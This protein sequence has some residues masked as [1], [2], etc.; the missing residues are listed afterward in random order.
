[1]ASVKM[2]SEKCARCTRFLAEGNT[3]PDRLCGY[4]QRAVNVKDWNKAGKPRVAFPEGAGR[5]VKSRRHAKSDPDVTSLSTDYL[6]K[7][8]R[9]LRRRAKS[10]AREA[11]LLKPFMEG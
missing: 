11:D 10:L 9:E 3:C 1:M 4:C 7:C 2:T 8:E 6:L 5:V